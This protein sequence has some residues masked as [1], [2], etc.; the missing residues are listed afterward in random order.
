MDARLPLCS[1]GSI[2]NTFGEFYLSRKPLCHR[3]SQVTLSQINYVGFR[4][5]ALLAS[6]PAPN[7]WSSPS[8]SKNRHFQS[9]FELL[10]GIE[11]AVAVLSVSYTHLTL[12]TKRIV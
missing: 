12:P 3:N 9:R 1:N 2:H 6:M 8:W 10:S 7:N 5:L 4:T 11:S